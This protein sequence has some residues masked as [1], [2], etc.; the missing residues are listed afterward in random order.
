MD[1]LIAF[2]LALV[3]IISCEKGDTFFRKS[4]LIVGEKTHCL[5]VDFKPDIALNPVSDSFDID[6]DNKYDIFF[7]LDSVFT[8]LCTLPYD[9][10]PNCDC[11]PS[12]FTVHTI[13]LSENTQI[14]IYLGSVI[15]EFEI[16]D[17]ISK[18]TIWSSDTQNSNYRLEVTN[19]NL[20]RPHELFL[21][22]RKIKDQDTLY[23]WVKIEIENDDY[24]VKIKESAIQK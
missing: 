24:S 4:Y 1:K 6:F 12:I 5:Y 14:A 17:T 21:G 10:C 20:D 16:N 19:F 15:D 13:T 23:S 8:E 18:A 22:L 9:S 7:K 2:L 3:F 11:W